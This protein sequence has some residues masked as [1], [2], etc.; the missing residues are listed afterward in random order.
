MSNTPLAVILRPKTLLEVIGQ[1][2]LIGPGKPLRKMADKGLFQS[3]ILWGPPGSGKTSIV[4]ALASETDSVF[5]ALNATE[6]TVKDVRKIIDGAK[7]RQPQRTIMFLDEV[8]RFNKSQQDVVLPVVE[9]GTIILFGATTEKPKFAVNSTILSRC[10][11][12]EVKPLD[13]QAMVDLIKRV[14]EFYKS[15]D[16]PIKIDPDA[17]KRIIMRCSGDARK[18]ITVLETVIEI[19]SDDRHVTMEHVN[20]AIPD[21]HLIFDAHGNDHYDLAHCYQEAIQHSDTDGAIYWLAKWLQSG[22]DPAYICRRMLITAFE[23]CAGNPSAWLAAMAACF[24]TERTGLPECMIPMALATCEMGKSDRNKSAYH[25]IKEAMSDVE[26]GKTV[27]VPPALRAGT[28]GYVKAVQKTYVK[29]WQKDNQLESERNNSCQLSYI[30]DVE[31]C[32]CEDCQ[33][34]RDNNPKPKYYGAKIESSRKPVINSSPKVYAI[35]M[36]HGPSTFA[37]THGPTPNLDEM[38]E[39]YG[40]D[41]DYIIEFTGSDKNPQHCQLYKWACGEWQKL[42]QDENWREWLSQQS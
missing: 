7:K 24:A 28:N 20:L 13:S 26:N 4:R 6:A 2:H 16:R 42:E 40:G 33:D 8:H 41:D 1:D 23:D 27:H 14:K 29:N 37:M 5:C 39:V 25:A 11:V 15:N 32:E 9:D 22:E 12:L 18:A 19:L 35:G 17:A 36:R 34:F 30:H 10:L 38:L 3:A 21:K 31:Q